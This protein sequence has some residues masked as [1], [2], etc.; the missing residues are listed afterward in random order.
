MKKAMILLAV[1]A[2]AGCA[3]MPTVGPVT[4]TAKKG[5]ASGV[6]QI[7]AYIAD[8]AIYYAVGRA[9]GHYLG[10]QESSSS[11]TTSTDTDNGKAVTLE[12]NSSYQNDIIINIDGSI[13][14][15]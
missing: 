1:L 6:V 15:E 13:G 2:L 3:S 10:K 12:L 9:V 4:A 11:T 8:G 7:G 14:G 5:N